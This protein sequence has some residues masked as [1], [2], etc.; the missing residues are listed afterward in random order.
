MILIHKHSSIL[1]AYRLALA[2]VVH[3]A[4]EPCAVDLNHEALVNIKIRLDALIKSSH[5]ALQSQ[6]FPI[7]NIAIE[8]YLNLRYQGTDNS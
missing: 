7:E 2:D 3:E 1:S 4:Q 5:E 6:G 8:I